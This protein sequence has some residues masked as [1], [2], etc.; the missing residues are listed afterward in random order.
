M[1]A[2]V[3]LP[4]S[5]IATSDSYGADA[6]KVLR[7]LEAV[8]KRPGMYIGDTD[9]GSGLHH[10][11]YEVVDNSVDEALAGHC[12]T[13]T[14][15][16]EEDGSVTVEDNG[17]GIPVGIHT[18][19]GI[20]A[21]EVIMTTLHAGGKFDQDQ[22]KVSGGLHGV[23]VSVVNALSERLNLT[24][25]R[26]GHEHHARFAR[27]GTQQSLT[28]GEAV[29]SSRSGTRV[30]FL[31]DEKIFSK[32]IFDLQQL[33]HRLR[34]LAFLLPSL[35]F[36]L[37]DARGGDQMEERYHYDGGL[38][39][40]VQYLD[41]KKDTL[42]AQMITIEGSRDGVRVSA[43]LQWTESFHETS[44][45][46]TNTIAQKDGG[47]HLAGLRLGLTRV[48]GGLINEQGKK[49]S[50]TGEDMREGLT[51]VLAVQM[52]DPKFS[53]QTKEKLVSSD[54]R[55]IVE[56]ITT[57]ALI[58][59][60][61]E[62][63]TQTKKIV[64][65]TIAAASS[66]EAA[67]K[68]RELTRRKGAL[69]ISSLPGKLADCQE[70]DPAKSELFIVEGESAGGT[71]KQGRHRHFQAIL[72]LKGK[73]LNVERV[74]DD[75]VF[76]SDEITALIAAIGTGTKDDCDI[77]KL[78]YH[79]IVIMTDADVDG[80][81]I[82]TLLLTFF[83][84]HM[85]NL[86]RSGYLYIAEP[87]LYRLSDGKNLEH[88]F[89][90]DDALENYLFAHG[91]AHLALHDGQGNALSEDSLLSLLRQARGSRALFEQLDRRIG[92]VGMSEQ[93]LFS[94]LVDEGDGDA[95]IARLVSRL[96]QSF[97]LERGS[98]EVTRHDAPWQVRMGH[99][100]HGVREEWIA[101]EV[102]RHE[103]ML[104]RKNLQSLVE[105]WRHSY[106]LRHKETAE[107]IDTPGRLLR[108]MREICS[109]NMTIQ[110][111]KGLGEMNAEQL[112]QTTLDPE[113]RSLAQVTLQDKE[114]D[115]NVFYT[116][117]GDKAEER[118]NFIQDH[119]SQVV[120]LDI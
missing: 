83:Y 40:Y 103:L 11:I 21:A 55:S 7:G 67:R 37:R 52:A 90:D 93:I 15:T 60:F 77:S 31:P 47:T 62:H 100:S 102:W 69:E 6:I 82:R 45:A 99:G 119:A 104:Y 56:A 32:T 117:M 71:A 116:L 107:C 78:R 38:S 29:E 19:E 63:P 46:F 41:R 114:E 61:E 94:G 34:E 120:N 118:R 101:D 98:W 74:R 97:P 49:I 20:S 106:E 112:W 2:S 108:R 54:V 1:N 53:S 73:I 17:R 88:Y 80:S 81:H 70:K 8:R 59:W 86:V 91:G 5:D 22:Y 84:R 44:L 14:I 96:N 10:M 72:P 23:G 87:P 43:A 16:L 28:K 33:D 12:D 85:E 76:A 68:A 51:S 3:P 18:E 79:K 13:I 42:H 110:R 9:D 115:D 113:K 26:D 25:W 35:T 36:I 65:K 27:G 24:I 50:I 95:G 89:K 30:S 75:R 66:R 105:N 4:K 57:E 109:K 48:L 64:A 58:R 39:A 111:Y 92:L